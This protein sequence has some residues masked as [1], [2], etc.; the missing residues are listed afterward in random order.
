MTDTHDA[1]IEEIVREFE[2][3]MT[4]SSLNGGW[5][6]VSTYVMDKPKDWLRTTLKS[7]GDSREARGRESMREDILSEIP[8]EDDGAPDRS[9]WSAGWGD[10][11]NEAINKIR[12]LPP[13]Q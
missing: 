4:T 8:M 10:Y 7:Y 3:K 2:V 9:N 11:R 6:Q 5:A 13:K 12:S 1:D